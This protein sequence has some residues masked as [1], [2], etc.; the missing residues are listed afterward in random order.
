[1]IDRFQVAGALRE[2]GAILDALGENRF[3]AR[4]YRRG[5]EAIEGSEQ[6][7]AALVDEG[8]LTALPGVGEGLARVVA[9][10]VRTGRSAL[11]E[12]LRAQVSPALL[13][14]AGLR[15]LS[16]ER[17]RALHEAL[18]IGTLAELEAACHAG[19]VREVRGFGEKTEARLLAALAR[20]RAGRDQRRLIDLLEPVERLLAHLAGAAEEVQVGG[21]VGRF[22]E[23]ASEVV[24]V[25][26]GPDPNA[27]AARLA[28]W[29]QVIGVEE[30]A[31]ERLR[32]RLASGLPVELWTA[33]RETW[34]G[35]QVQARGAPEHVAAL[36]ARATALGLTLAP[37]GLCDARSGARLALADEAALYERLG[38]PWLPPEVREDGDSIAAALEGDDFRDLIAPEHLRGATHCHTVWS[39]GVDTIEA[40]G[41]AAAARGLEYLTITDHSQSA[42][43]A[44]GLDPARLRAQAQEI[45]R[46]QG[47]L[48]LRLIRGTECDILPDGALDFSPAEL[49]ALELVIAS[50]HARQRLDEEQQTRRLVRALR[51]PPFK[52]WGHPLGQLV[53]R[54]PPIECR[55]EEVLDAAAEG[56]AA[57]EVNGDPYRLDLPARWLRAARARGLRFLLSSDAHSAGGLDSVSFAVGTARRG[58]VRRGEVLNALP[59]AEFLAAVRPGRAGEPASATGKAG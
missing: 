18:G 33:T 47:Q 10:L 1:M 29:P 26:R 4:A 52:V 23:S 20:H 39:D 13:E 35:A 54:R 21:A 3:R 45:A 16:L 24:L 41:R 50:V 7:L 22:A 42:H 57:I 46:L 19:R 12:Q 55:V 49:Q 40:M 58:W 27:L 43:Y 14:L 59:A 2:I 30:R 11:L 37:H 25:A 38:L 36:A 51:A 56:P 48:G 15:G 5:A 6:D 32:V 53:L 9:E 8:R 34:A 31:P 44:G 17:A 28:G